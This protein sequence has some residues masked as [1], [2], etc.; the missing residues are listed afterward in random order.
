MWPNWVHP[1]TAETILLRLRR[2]AIRSNCSLLSSR[3]LTHQWIHSSSMDS[4]H[5]IFQFLL[6]RG[7]ACW[8]A[9]ANPNGRT[10]LRNSIVDLIF[11]YVASV[12][13]TGCAAKF[14][15]ARSSDRY[16]DF[17][18]ATNVVTRWIC[19]LCRDTRADTDHVTIAGGLGLI[20]SQAG[21]RLTYHKDG[22]A[23]LTMLPR[24]QRHAWNL[25]IFTLAPLVKSSV[26]LS[27]VFRSDAGP[28]FAVDEINDWTALFSFVVG[29][30]V[31][32]VV[33]WAE[34]AANPNRMNQNAPPIQLPP[35][36]RA[37]VDLRRTFDNGNL[38]LIPNEFLCPL[39]KVLFCNPVVACDGHTY[40]AEMIMEWFQNHETSPLTNVAVESKVT[41]PNFALRSLMERWVAPQ[42]GLHQTL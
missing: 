19:L 23:L 22:G 26:A 31:G 9:F 8:S 20:A 40:E 14:L 11:S 35:D 34:Q 18:Q 36:L 7:D 27:D 28:I 39:T 25:C 1:P 32:Q 21:F 29:A 6:L 16:L 3:L 15:K 41:Y 4:V 5:T 33:R 38:A 37:S 12:V 30:V 24:L 10:F 42:T 17:Y 2:W 13:G